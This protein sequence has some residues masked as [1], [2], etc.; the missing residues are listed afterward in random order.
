MPET[1]SI[2]L[3]A[4]SDAEAF[5]ALR[6]KGLKEEPRAF[7]ASYEESSAEALSTVA[8]RLECNDDGFLMGS[9][10]KDRLVGVTGFYRYKE[11]K[12]V[13]H[14]GVVWGVYLLPEY[15]GKGIAR[16]LLLEVIER[17]KS[18]PGIELLHL[19]VDPSNKPVVK[20]YESVGFTKWGTELHALKIG[21]EYVD[22]DQMVLW[23]KG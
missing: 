7:T 6:L 4:P 14:K 5:W 20:L 19:G 16:R 22:E 10:D 15:R 12:K 3:L 17:C 11:G 21:D 1:I 23:T 18:V 9:F 8:K 2:R 13:E